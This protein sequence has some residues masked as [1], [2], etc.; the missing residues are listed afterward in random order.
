MVQPLTIVQEIKYKLAL[1]REEANSGIKSTVE[2]TKNFKDS[3]KSQKYFMGWTNFE[4]TWYVDIDNDPWKV[5]PLKR[6][7]VEEWHDV[8]RKFVPIITPEGEIVT[9]EEWEKRNGAKS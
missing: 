1:L 3:F 5:I 4:K 2:I 9:P 6:P 8:L 7:L